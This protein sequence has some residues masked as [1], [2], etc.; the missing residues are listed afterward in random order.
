[1]EYDAGV[2]PDRSLPEPTDY[3]IWGA[4][5]L[6]ALVLGLGSAFFL[7][8]ALHRTDRVDLADGAVASLGLGLLLI[9]MAAERPATRVFCVLLA[10]VLVVGFALGGPEFARLAP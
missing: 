6:L 3:V 9:G 10:V 4:S 8:V 7:W 5:G 1:V 2:M